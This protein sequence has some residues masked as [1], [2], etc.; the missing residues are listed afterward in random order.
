MKNSTHDGWW[1]QGQQAAADHRFCR[2]ACPVCSEC[3]TCGSCICDDDEREID[4]PP[5]AGVA[6]RAAAA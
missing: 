6:D 2:G 1:L 3:L 4:R 5:A